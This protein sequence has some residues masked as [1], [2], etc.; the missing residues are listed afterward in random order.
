MGIT[1]KN[2]KGEYA[3]KLIAGAICAVMLMIFSCV[4]CLL[5]YRF[6]NIVAIVILFL[7]AF[8]IV[9]R[10]ANDQ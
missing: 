7:F 4:A 10:L 1:P 2:K 3:I 9:C 6:F 5:I 8:G